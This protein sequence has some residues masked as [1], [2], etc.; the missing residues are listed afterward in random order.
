MHFN[1]TNL[2]HQAILSCVTIRFSS[3]LIRPSKNDYLFPVTCFENIENEGMEHFI[4]AK[5]FML[6]KYWDGRKGKYFIFS[7]KYIAYKHI[8]YLL[9]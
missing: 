1:F 6:S 2:N 5:K 3:I 9:F 7:K 4:L 8:R